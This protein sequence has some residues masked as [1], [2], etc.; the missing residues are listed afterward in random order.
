[1]T[2]PPTPGRTSGPPA[3]PDSPV[4]FRTRRFIPVPPAERPRR[5]RRAT[6]VVVTDGVRVL[7]FADTDPGIPGS[8]WWVTPGG[9]I[10]PGESEVEA[11]V[12]E[13]FE[14]TGLRV[15]ASDLVGPVATRTVVHGYSDQVLSQHETF[16]VVRTRAF[17]PDTSGHSADEQVTL[18]GHRWVAL[19]EVD[20][21][22][23]PVW[24]AGL[25]W[26]VAL[27]DEA[28]LGPR[29]LGTVEESTLPV[30]AS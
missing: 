4:A 19:D 5:S 21:L 24:P 15:A 22:P 8:R 17:E 25:A 30:D 1:M 13:V 6:R 18:S 12:R 7:L 20:A 28:H 23:E 27:A 2:Q 10:D 3:D 14:E 11:G 26:F 29:A 16:F 9:G